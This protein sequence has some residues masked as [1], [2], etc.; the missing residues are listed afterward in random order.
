MLG[1]RLYHM[2]KGFSLIELLVVVAIIG[3]LAAVG[4]VAYSGYTATAKINT[5]KSQHAEIVKYVSREFMKCDLGHTTIFVNPYETQG[6]T[7]PSSNF[8]DDDGRT[9][10]NALAST[11]KNAY[12]GSVSAFDDVDSSFDSCQEADFDAFPEGDFPIPPGCHYIEFDTTTNS[13]TIFSGH[14]DDGDQTDADNLDDT[15]ITVVPAN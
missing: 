10:S 14:A 2:N 4:V 12:D 5:V 8:T 3:I 6:A 11:F 15:L 7:C 9:A 1:D 13:M